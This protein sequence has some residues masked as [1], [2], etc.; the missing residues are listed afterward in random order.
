MSWAKPQPQKLTAWSFSRWSVYDQCPLKAKLQFI[1]KIQEPSDP[2]GPMARGDAIHKAAQAYIEGPGRTMKLIPELKGVNSTL[3]MLRKRYRADPESMTVEQTWAFKSDWTRTTWNDWRGCWLRIKVDVS[4]QEIDEDVLVVHVKDW[5]SGKFSPQYNLPEYLLQLD[6]YATGAL[7][8]FNDDDFPK[9]RVL[10]HL[11][12]T[13]A[14][15]TYP[16]TGE[17]KVYTQKDKKRLQ[18][19]WTNRVKPMLN[20]TTFQAK[21]NSKC[22]WCFY[23]QAG[24]VKGGPGICRY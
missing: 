20:D 8:I 17:E 22:R 7:T 16:A 5:K 13:D 9:V 6:L 4:W 23:G 18:K 11:H 19:E 2:N 1:D 14:Q 12:Y 21:P 10:P 3:Q 15:L 24:K